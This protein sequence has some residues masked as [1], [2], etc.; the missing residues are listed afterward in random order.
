MQISVS[1]RALLAG[2]PAASAAILTTGAAPTVGREDEAAEPFRY[3]LN[4][5]TI[6]GQN[7]GIVSAIE[8]AAKAGYSGIEPWINELEQF[9]KEG[10]SLSDLAQ[11]I[12]DC[13]LRVESVIGF[14]PWLV[15]DDAERAGGLETARR[16]MERVHTIGGRRLAA[17]PAGATRA[18]VDLV[19]A[20]R[21]YRNLLELGE[22]MEVVPQLEVWGFSQSLNRLSDVVWVAMESGH[23]QACLLADVYHLYKGGSSFESL[24]LVSGRA[25]HVVHMNDYPAAP[26]RATINDSHRVYPGDGVAPLGQIVRDLNAIGFR[27]ALS[28]ELFNPEYWKQD[29]LSVARTGLEKM[30]QV[31]AASQEA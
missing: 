7:L 1:R 8:V 31:V 11:R 16:D 28:L 15:D 2:L 22:T 10:G 3:C 23:P 27:G 17:P 12:A 5:S 4:T 24:K 9:V 19:Q 20:A 29:A 13:G 25:M 18:P 26:D 6:R 14:A 21:R 30:R